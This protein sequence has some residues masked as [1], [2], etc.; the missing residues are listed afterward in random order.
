MGLALRFDETTGQGTLEETELPALLLNGGDVE[1]ECAFDESNAAL[2]PLDRQ[3]HWTLGVRASDGKLYNVC[4][5]RDG[6]PKR[7]KNLA[8]LLA[9]VRRSKPSLRKIILPLYPN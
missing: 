6:A 3:V 9:V 2:P 4:K 8:Q 7:Y 1:I 5:A